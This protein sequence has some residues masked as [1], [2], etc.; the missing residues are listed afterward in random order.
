MAMSSSA[1]PIYLYGRFWTASEDAS[2][3]LS[4]HATVLEQ[5]VWGAKTVPSGFFKLPGSENVSAVL[6]NPSATISKFNRMGVL[7]GFGSKR[8]RLQRTGVATNNEADAAEPVHFSMEG[9]SPD[10]RETWME[11]IDVFHNPKAKIPLHP[12]MLAGAAHHFLR[13]DGQLESLIPKWHPMG[14]FTHI[15]IVE[16]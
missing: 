15:S 7:A 9:N 12:M 6:A 5:H 10:Y 16:E 14:S 2:G 8:V 4:V 1:L 11:G 13:E 3:A